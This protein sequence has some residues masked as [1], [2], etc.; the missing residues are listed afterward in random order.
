MVSDLA[1]C[2]VFTITRSNGAKKWFRSLTLGS[3]TSWQQLSTSFLRQFQ[4]TKQFA[5][6]LAHLGNV[7]Q[8]EGESLKSFLNHFTTE[9]S[10]VRW[11]LDAGVLVHLTNGVLL[12][13][14]FWDTLHQKE[15][16]NESEF[17][18]KASKFLKLKNS[19]EA[20]HKT[21]EATADRKNDQG[22]KVEKEKKRK[23]V[24][25]KE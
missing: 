11:A 19:S 25:K 23:E 9:L 2:M 3:V 20:L 15:S 1:K 6:Q 13:T 14:P 12:E 8:N 16:N 7:K 17:Y 10:R 21:K 5:V 22:E 4:A 24:R 18:K